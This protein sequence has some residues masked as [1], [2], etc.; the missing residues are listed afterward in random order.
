MT[1]TT[2]PKGDHNEEQLDLLRA[3]LLLMQ[4]MTESL[5]NHDLD[6]LERQVAAGEGLAS[7]MDSL[8]QRS[9]NVVDPPAGLNSVDDQSQAL[10]G[11][12]AGGSV[13]AQLRSELERLGEEIRQVTLR[14]RILI[15][16]G[17]QFAETLLQAVCPSPTYDPSK[18][19]SS[20]PVR[21][22]FSLNY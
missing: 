7:R 9:Q 1:T 5:R 8:N 10:P 18:P 3:S 21:S 6:G 2:K 22:T 20:L 12:K 16:T 11:E 4:E 17:R 14:N 19:T 15:E 13:E